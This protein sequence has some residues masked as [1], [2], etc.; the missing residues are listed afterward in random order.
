MSVETNVVVT[1]LTKI[2]TTIIIDGVPP[3][4]AGKAVAAVLARAATIVS[5]TTIAAITPSPVTV[6]VADSTNH[7]HQYCVT[8]K[9]M[10][11]VAV[12]TRDLI[13]DPTAATASVATESATTIDITIDIRI[14]EADL[15]TAVAALAVETEAAGRGEEEEIEVIRAEA[16]VTLPEGTEGRRETGG[17]GAGA[18]GGAARPVMAANAAVGAA[19]EVAGAGTGERDGI[20]R[21]TQEEKAGARNTTREHRRS[22]S[23]EGETESEEGGGT[24]G[25]PGTATITAA[26]AVR[27]GGGIAPEAPTVASVVGDVTLG[28]TAQKQKNR[29]TASH[30]LSATLVPVEVE[31]AVIPSCWIVSGMAITGAITTTIVAIIGDRHRDAA[32]LDQANAIIVAPATTI[33]AA[34]RAA[35]VGAEPVEIG[36]KIATE[37]AVVTMAAAARRMTRIRRTK[38]AVETITTKQFSLGTITTKTAVIQGV[39]AMTEVVAIGIKAALDGEIEERVERL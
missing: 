35:V 31:A 22:L 2:T 20:A 30:C 3:P 13:R 6:A 39:K 1:V 8:A 32:N 5:D 37:A 34:P 9:S 17:N 25:L 21:E 4:G 33:S 28:V 26:V 27:V 29:T 15:P 14:E 23:R 19:A 24:T 18:G 16:V 38:N 36:F 10:A 11:A 7:R 12:A